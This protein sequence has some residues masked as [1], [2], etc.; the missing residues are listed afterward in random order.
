MNKF[1]DKANTHSEA[2]SSEPVLT[3]WTKRTRT[4]KRAVV[5]LSPKRSVGEQHLE[6]CES[7]TP[8]PATVR[9][10]KFEAAVTTLD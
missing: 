2:S 4:A 1:F 10:G 5:S 6:K 9:G 7:M 8:T 3:K